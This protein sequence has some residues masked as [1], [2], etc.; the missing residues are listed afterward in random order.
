MRAD[1]LDDEFSP[2][3]ADE[4]A[5]LLPESVSVRC[6]E[7]KHQ[8]TDA[9]VGEDLFNELLGA[10]LA[11]DINLSSHHNIIDRKPGEI[12]LVKF[13]KT[14]NQL[15]EDQNFAVVMPSMYDQQQVMQFRAREQGY[16][17]EGCLDKRPGAGS[18]VYTLDEVNLSFNENVTKPTTVYVASKKKSSGGMR[19]HYI[20]SITNKPT[21]CTWGYKSMRLLKLSSGD[22]LR[23]VKACPDYAHIMLSDALRCIVSMAVIKKAGISSPGRDGKY[24]GVLAELIHSNPSVSITHELICWMCMTEEQ[25]YHEALACHADMECSNPYEVYSLFSRHKVECGD[26]MLY[27]PLHNMI[28]RIRSNAEMMVLNFSKTLHVPDQSRNK[29]NF[30]RVHL[31]LFD[32]AERKSKRIS[33]K[34]AKHE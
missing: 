30:S 15:P 34:R 24:L 4:L 20:S 6:I 22:R 3:T 28:L 11:P 27:F 14:D 5:A 1:L 8:I 25:R 18:G 31:P 19:A 2:E 29:E 10:S 32:M 23:D 17:D 7:L 26:G 33:N 16:I 12:L 21:I 9:A 13:P